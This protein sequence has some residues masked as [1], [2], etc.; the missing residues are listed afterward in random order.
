M[1]VCARAR[2]C[3][4]ARARVPGV[5]ILVKSGHRL[6]DQTSPG[7]ELRHT[8][9]TEDNDILPHYV[10]EHNERTSTEFNLLRA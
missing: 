6:Y 10:Q 9:T 1:C 5:S 4:C 2:V 3:V 8:H 7:Q